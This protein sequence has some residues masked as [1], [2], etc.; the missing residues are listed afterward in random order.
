MLRPDWTDPVPNTFD[1]N[2]WLGPAAQRPFAARWPAGSLPLV[3]TNRQSVNPAVYH[4]WNFRGWYD[5]GTG[6]L[7]DMGCHHWNTPR[8]ALKLGHPTA[9]SA[10]STKVMPE[11]WPLA[12]IIT[13]E[14]P[15]RGSMP[16]VQITWYDGGLKPPRPVEM[17]A[18]T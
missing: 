4:P 2:L 12:S 1:W 16:P 18:E 11:T 8:R 17:E 14:F 6:A 7:G 3:Q 10:T 15:A 13:Y 9:V 5:F